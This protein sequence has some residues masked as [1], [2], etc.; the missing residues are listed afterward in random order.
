MESLSTDC[1]IAG[2]GPAG[3]MAGLLLA[4][5]G[6]DVVVLEKHAD[7]LR[8]FRGDTIHPSTLELIAELGVLD[9]FLARPHT[10]VRQIAVEIGKERFAVGDFT[11]VPTR[12]KFL[13]LMPQWDFLDFLLGEAERYDNFRLKMQAE[14]TDLLARRGRIAGLLARTPDGLLEVRAKLVLGADGRTST[15]RAK[16]SLPVREF[17]APFDVLWLRL[18]FVAGDPTEPVARFQGG[19]FFIML[20]RGDYWQCAFVIPKGAFATM[21][22]EGL[23]GF[24]ARLRSVAGFARDRVEAIQSFEDVKLLTVKVDRLKRWARRGLLCIGDAA[25][26]MSPV[27]GVGINLAIQD[28]V[29]TANLL[30][31][32]LKSRV[33]RRSDLDKVQRRREWPTRVVQWFQVQVQKRVLAPN[34]RARQTPRPPFI[35]YVMRRFPA[36][37]R[38]PARFVGVGVRPEHIRIN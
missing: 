25:H 21:K 23:T 34:L 10:E 37:R 8:D 6:V 19:D 1:V 14:V 4:R 32:V 13:A 27:G 17:G 11:Q 20:Y 38:I 35:L 30:A 18:P 3:M 33:P 9:K 31:P 12:C 5:A 2:G 7:F 15:V 29:A 22:A 16:A 26:A 36:L 24:R 28:A